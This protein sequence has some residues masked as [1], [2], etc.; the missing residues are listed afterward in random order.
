MKHYQLQKEKK[1][2][3]HYPVTA[4]FIFKTCHILLKKKMKQRKLPALRFLLLPTHLCSDT[5]THA[6]HTQGPEDQEEMAPVQKLQQQP[7]RHPASLSTSA[8]KNH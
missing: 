3:N 5:V 7:Y 8:S 6:A 1:G 4:L 2:L